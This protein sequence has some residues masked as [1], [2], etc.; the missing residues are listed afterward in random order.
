MITRMLFREENKSLSSS[1]CTF[2]YS[3]F[4]SIFLGQN[5]LLSTLFW[6]TLSLCSSL[7]VSDHVS[8]PYK[9]TGK[10]TVLFNLILVCL[11]SKLEDKSF[12]TDWQPAFPLFNLFL[13]YFWI[14]FEIF[15]LFRSFQGTIISL[16]VLTSSSTLISRHDHVLSFTSI[17]F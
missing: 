12:Y 17:Y 4:T 13:F 10:I 5:I 16:Y 6:N 9:T 1:L 15:E 11:D 7:N 3:P 2:L 8:G 14:K